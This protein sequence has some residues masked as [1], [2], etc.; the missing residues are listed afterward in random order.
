[1]REPRRQAPR[2]IAALWSGIGWA[3][4]TKGAAAVVPNHR[5]APALSLCWQPVAATG[6]GCAGAVRQREAR[7]RAGGDSA[8]DRA[9]RRQARYDRGLQLARRAE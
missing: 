7:G 1:M 6:T 2:M 9:E 8:Q 4:G 5:L 3:A